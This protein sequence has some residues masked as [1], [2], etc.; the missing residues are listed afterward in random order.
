[1]TL[2]DRMQEI[3][4]TSVKLLPHASTWILVLFV[5][6]TAC[7]G[8]D[9][10]PAAEGAKY[11]IFTAD[12]FGAARNINEG[13]ELAADNGSLTAIS[14]LMNFRE[15][16]EDLKAIAAAHPVI[17]IG[18]HLNLT[19]GKPLSD[20]GSIPSLLDSKGNFFPV[21][22]FFSRIRQIDPEEAALELDAQIRALQDVGI[23]VD[24]LSDHNGVLSI[25]PL[26]STFLFR[27]QKSTGSP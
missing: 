22:E 26:F 19:T 8:V 27:S 5:F 1:M 7:A 15:S 2:A 12:D 14:A 25:Y 13:I 10:R 11:V 20:P 17:G 16:W 23:R 21:E 3:I 4:N 24:H 18:V 6:M 9:T